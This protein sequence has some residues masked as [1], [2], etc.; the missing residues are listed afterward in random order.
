M[1]STKSHPLHTYVH[2]Q[3]SVEDLK[4]FEFDNRNTD[5]FFPSKVKY[6]KSLYKKIPKTWI[7][8]KGKWKDYILKPVNQGGCGS[9]WAYS[10]VN[11]LSDRYNIWAK[12]RILKKPLSPFLILT[13]NIFAT[14]FQ[15]QELVQN[16]DYETWN[17]ETG[18]YGN[19]LLASLLYIYC[20]G[21]QTDE[22]FPYDIDDLNRYK[23][24]RTNFAFYEP[25]NANIEL[26]NKTFN[27]KDFTPDISITPSCAFAT[28]SQ[29]IPFMICQ[30]FI[31]VNKSQMYGS[32]VQNFSITHFYMV[33]SDMSQ[34]QLEILSNGPVVS[35][36]LVYE[37]FYTFDAKSEVYQ[38][39]VISDEVP[40]GGHAV[41][42]VGWGVEKGVPFWWIKNTWGVD[43]GI[44]GYFRFY[45]GKNMCHI[46]QNVHGFFPDMYL[47]YQNFPFLR[48]VIRSI[49]TTKYV[50]D[51]V[52]PE[53]VT[54]IRKVIQYI[55][56]NE[57][58]TALKVEEG[59]DIS[60]YF[61]KY[62]SFGYAIYLRSSLHFMSYTNN[63]IGYFPG[64]AMPF[65]QDQVREQLPSKGFFKTL[66]AIKK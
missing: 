12:Q 62:G 54:T 51:I 14:F 18:C 11:T 56:Q 46:E 17:K 10:V 5:K 21:V 64:L 33:E 43:Y 9:C 40:V 65:Q 1:Y 36:F 6:P 41:E 32:I 20:F 7:P 48:K 26:M 60:V 44:D 31:D 19:I 50:E 45:R 22:C 8:Q 37:D 15:N 39:K 13:C 2:N 24:Q 42:I 49:K 23:Q 58:K 53:L 3:G 25:S 34:I 66:Y 16:V 57:H 55:L 29:R 61:E 59:K 27:F 52:T 47:D 4:K 30:D 38:H 35:A 28:K 63:F